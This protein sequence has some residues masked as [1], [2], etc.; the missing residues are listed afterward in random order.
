MG[1]ERDSIGSLHHWEWLPGIDSQWE[2]SEHWWPAL[3][4]AEK[5]VKGIWPA[6][7]GDVGE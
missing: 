3:I 4:A 2:G 1:G 6:L 5:G 7:I